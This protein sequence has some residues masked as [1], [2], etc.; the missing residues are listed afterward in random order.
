MN[1]KIRECNKT[2]LNTLTVAQ[3]RF[4]S[5]FQL[6]GR[7]FFL[8]GQITKGEIKQGQFMDL[9]ML[10]L[11]KKPKIKAVEFV[12]KQQDG[13]VWEDIGLG[14]DG[15]IY[16]TFSNT[17]WNFYPPK[18]GQVGRDHSEDEPNFH[19]SRRFGTTTTALRNIVL[20]P[21]IEWCRTKHHKNAYNQTIVI[22]NKTNQSILSIL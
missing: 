19:Y 2:N 18:T 14:T 17:R 1:I 20:S 22:D 21:D 11:S 7:C 13:K 15:T 3:F 12:R 10:G 5:S 9:T 16:V 4:D 6:T 8:L